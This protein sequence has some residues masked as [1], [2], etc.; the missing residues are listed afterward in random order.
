MI[1]N[2]PLIYSVFGVLSSHCFSTDGSVLAERSCTD[3]G[4][5]TDDGILFVANL[6]FKCWILEQKNIMTFTRKWRLP[7]PETV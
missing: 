5:V 2:R 4:I 7:A 1:E 6:K 3:S